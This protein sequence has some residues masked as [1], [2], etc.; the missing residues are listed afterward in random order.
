MAGRFALQAEARK[1][2]SSRL[3]PFCHAANRRDYC[4]AMASKFSAAL[5]RILRDVLRSLTGTKRRTPAKT[6][7]TSR[8]PGDYSG[9]PKLV[10]G[11]HP[12]NVADPGEIVWTWVPFE[13]DHSQGKDRPVLIVGRDGDWLLA[14]MLTSKDHDA[15]ARQEARYGRYWVDI[16]TG[17]WDSQRRP[18]EVRV[19]RIIRVDPNQ[20][21]R[22]SAALPEKKFKSVATG[23]RRHT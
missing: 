21:R 1:Q 7:K 5:G 8:S 23:I 15:D 10:Y 9:T 18:S 14:V 17:P 20:V 22:V 4:D 11:P 13:E 2:S 19:D 6:R 16:G 12:G 3:D